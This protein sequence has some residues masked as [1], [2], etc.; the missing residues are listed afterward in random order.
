MQEG[1][2]QKDCQIMNSART[3]WSQKDYIH[4]YAVQ[5][6]E[7]FKN[8][9]RIVERYTSIPIS[10]IFMIMY[11]DSPNLE[12]KEGKLKCDNQKYKDS[13]IV[14]DYVEKLIPYCNIIGG[15]KTVFLNSLMFV[16][17]MDLV[18]RNRLFEVIKKNCH[19]MTPAVNT[20]MALSEIE[21]VYNRMLRPSTRIY[22]VTEWKK[23]KGV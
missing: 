10:A 13:V 7:D 19:S 4:Y 20:E 5:G 8:I 1:L 12:I 23:S 14:L 18:D 9:Q 3:S 15:R 16:Y 6:N 2:T 17:N 11:K 21:R 22:P